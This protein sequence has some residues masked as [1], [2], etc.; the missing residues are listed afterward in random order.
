MVKIILREI[1]YYKQL[2]TKV[3]MYLKNKSS[4][5]TKIPYLNLSN[6]NKNNTI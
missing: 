6:T 2:N 1:V 4:K 5:L 3:I